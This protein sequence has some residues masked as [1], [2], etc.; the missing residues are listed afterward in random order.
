MT[1]SV[2]GFPCALS[3]EYRSCCES[4]RPRAVGERPVRLELSAQVARRVAHGEPR[5][6][7]TRV[8]HRALDLKPWELSLQGGVGYSDTSITTLW[9]LCPARCFR[10]AT[11]HDRR[12]GGQGGVPIRR[13]YR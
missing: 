3:T 1:S 12:V 4:E 5:V 13:I 10:G 6:G 2:T 9:S 11:F 7:G 8:T